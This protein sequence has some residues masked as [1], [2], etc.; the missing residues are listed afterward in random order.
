MNYKIILFM[1]S[2]KEFLKKQTL[3]VNQKF[4]YYYK[5]YLS[6]KTLEKNPKIQIKKNLIIKNE[7]ST[8][9]NKE[10]VALV[11]YKNKIFLKPILNCEN[12][13]LAPIVYN[14]NVLDFMEY[15]QFILSKLPESSLVKLW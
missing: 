1:K 6:L 9:V 7:H 10:C 14:E 3:F 15:I 2:L 8:C 4:N 5:K 12:E 13:L 11:E